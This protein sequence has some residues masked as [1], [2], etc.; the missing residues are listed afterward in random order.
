ML[1]LKMLSKQQKA[2]LIM[3]TQF[4]IILLESWMIVP[5]MVMLANLAL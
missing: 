5:A 1:L 2:M 3:N 4:V